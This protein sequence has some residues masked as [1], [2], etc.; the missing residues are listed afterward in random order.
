M[1]F[2]FVFNCL[3][4]GGGGW[5]LRLQTITHPTIT[6]KQIHLLLCQILSIC[7][8][9]FNEFILF[10]RLHLFTLNFFF[11]NKF[12]SALRGAVLTVAHAAGNRL[13]DSYRH[14]KV[15]R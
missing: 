15:Q 4:D 14:L 3:T 7:T 10:F 1:Y 6:S 8:M 9:I 12:L 13:R 5:A 2:P 11:T